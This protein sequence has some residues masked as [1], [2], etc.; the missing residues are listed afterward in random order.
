[1]KITMNASTFLID[2]NAYANAVREEMRKVFLKAGQRFLLAAIP[3]I[4]VFTG[5]ARGAFRNAED[6][7]G[8]VS[9]DDQSPTGFR[10]RG[11]RGGGTSPTAQTRIGTSIVDVSRTGYYY[12][13]PTGRILRT[14]EAG[15][16]FATDPGDILKASLVQSRFGMSFKFEVDISYVNYLDDAKW[17][18]FQA[19]QEAFLEYVNA[20]LKLPSPLK[21]QIRKTYKTS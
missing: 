19:G 7:F 16:Q 5:M 11:G 21:F 3:R 1:M 12:N 9:L 13:A 20:N 17:G 14:P 15:R 10:I 18:A 4:P 2:T 6:V 8:K